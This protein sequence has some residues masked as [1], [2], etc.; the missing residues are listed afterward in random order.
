MILA[1]T[2]FMMCGKSTYGYAVATRL[3]LP[4]IDLDFE[5]E[6]GIAP[7]EII[8]TKGEE[9]FRQEETEALRCVLERESDCILALG[10]GTPLRE[11]NR[12]LLRRHCRVVWIKA[13][14]E[15][16]VFN[17]EWAS[18][19]AQRPLLAGGDR[20]RITSLWESRVPVYESVADYT[21]ETDGK[22]PEEIISE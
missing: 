17:P 5:I 22:T 8:R 11:E 19:A 3:G 18:L 7:G 13:S 21:V 2:G 6:P 14:L 20:E 15:Q 4:F 12:E 9:V 10:G 16:S 1:L